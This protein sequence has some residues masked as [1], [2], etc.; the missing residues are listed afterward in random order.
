MAEEMSRGLSKLEIYLF[1]NNM[2]GYVWPLKGDIETSN[3]AGPNSLLS[4]KDIVRPRKRVIVYGDAEMSSDEFDYDN[5]EP[6][7]ND[8]RVRRFSMRGGD[9]LQYIKRNS[10]SSVWIN[11]VFKKEWEQRDDSGTIRYA[12]DIIKMYDLSEGGVEDAIKQLM[13][14]R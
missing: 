5:W 4:I 3:Y 6:Q 7:D 13:R 14:K 12:G 2:Y 10:K 9:C 1:H 11:P 8:S